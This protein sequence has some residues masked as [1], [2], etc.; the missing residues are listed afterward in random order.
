MITIDGSGSKFLTRV[1]SGQPFMVWGWFWKISL[2]N[3]KFFNFCPS[4]QKKSLRVGSKAVRPLIYCWSKVSSG[5]GLS[6]MITQTE[7]RQNQNKHWYLV[8]ILVPCGSERKFWLKIYQ[9]Q[10][11]FNTIGLSARCRHNW[12]N[13]SKKKVVSSWKQT[14][15]FKI[16]F[17]FCSLATLKKKEP[18]GSP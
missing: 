4:G 3:V 5:H 16:F 7:N 10:S 17:F 13:G 6:L 18:E 15:L 1:R 11:E 2:K 9:L 8:F 14:Q 12:T